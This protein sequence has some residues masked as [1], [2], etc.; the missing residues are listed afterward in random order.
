MTM[1]PGTTIDAREEAWLNGAT[2]VRR[3]NLRI[4]A[5]SLWQFHGFRLTDGLNGM[6]RWQVPPGAYRVVG[7]GRHVRTMT[8]L[9][10]HVGVGG[11]DDGLMY[12]CPLA[13]WADCFTPIET[14]VVKKAVAP[15]LTSEQ[16]SAKTA[17]WAVSGVWP[18]DVP[19]AVQKPDEVASEVAAEKMFGSASFGSGW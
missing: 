15:K 16:L 9:V 18:E 3:T 19:A 11:P 12:F 17:A 13:S 5:G 2:D 8:E 6:V 10:A 1:T 4:V 14:P 7:V